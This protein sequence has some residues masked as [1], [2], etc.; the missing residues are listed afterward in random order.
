LPDDGKCERK[1]K[2]EEILGENNKLK[3]CTA[4]QIRENIQTKTI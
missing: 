3:K 2:K 1:R 4:M